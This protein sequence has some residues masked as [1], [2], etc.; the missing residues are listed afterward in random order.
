MTLF[1]I[2]LDNRTPPKNEQ[3]LPRQN[4]ANLSER[5]EI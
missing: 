1:S 5:E 3:Q 2:Y 4:Q